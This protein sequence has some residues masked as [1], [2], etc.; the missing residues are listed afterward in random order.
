[1][2]RLLLA[3]SAL[4]LLISSCS[5][6]SVNPN[7]TTKPVHLFC[8]AEKVSGDMLVG[9][10]GVEFAN[11]KARSKKR[12][13][14]G[15]YSLRLHKENAY[16]YGYIIKDVKKGTVITAE[17][18]KNR[19]AEGGA[20]V[21]S[22][23]GSNQNYTSSGHF[24]ELE[25]EWGKVTTM[26]IAEQ[27]F[28]SLNVYTY[29]LAQKPVYFDDFKIGIYRNVSKP[30]I[31]SGA[32]VLKIE[33]PKSAQDSLNNFQR[34]ALEQ[35]VISS[36][37]KEYVKAYVD[38]NGEKAPVEL[39]LKGD[40]TD[41]VETE[42]VSFRIKMGDGY[43][44]DGLRT[45]SIQHPQTRSYA[46]EWFAHQL[47]EEE[48]ILTTR[49]EMIPVIINGKN[50]GVYAMEEHF[51]KQLLE[52]RKRREGPIMKFDESGIWAVHKNLKETGDYVGAP[53]IESAEISV[54]KKGRTKRTPTLFAQFKEAQSNMEKYR[55]GAD[56][57]E[58]Y[59]DI[60]ST[61]KYLALIEL[62]NGKHGLTWH[63]Q[64]FYFNPITQRLEPIAYDCFME[65]NL[66]IKQHEL[67]ALKEPDDHEFL[68]TQGILKD[69][70]LLERYEFYLE[71][72]SDP[73]YLS[74]MFDKLSGKI[75]K[76]EKLLSYEYPN[77]TV[78]KEHFEFNRT[79]ITQDLPQVKGANLN[80]NYGGDFGVLPDNFM[81]EEVA[82]KANL[83]KYNADSSAQMSLRN[84]HSHPIEIIGYTV[85]GD[86]IGLI[87][88]DPILLKAYGSGES[89]VVRFP[90]KPRRIHYKAA[91]CGDQ[92]FKCNP[93][94]WPQ[95]KVKKSKWYDAERD[96]SV[97][98]ET[99]TIS[100]KLTLNKGLI[101][102]AYKELV[103]E[104][105]AEIVLGSGA[106][107]VSHAPVRAEGT[108]ENPII[109]RGTSE[110]T[111]G[112]VCLSKEDSKLT[113]VTFDNLG[114]MHEENWRLTGAVTFYDASVSIDHCTFK[115]NHCEDGLNTISCNVT[116]SN[117]IVENTYSDG[118]DADFCTGSV[119][120]STFTNTGN[121]CI[122]FSGSEFKIINCTIED[123]G[124]KGISGGESSTLTVVDCT[125]NGA[126]IAV[127]SKDASK[128]EVENITIEKSDVAFSVYA[129][130]AEY[131][132]AI[133]SVKSVKKNNAKELK[134]L[135]K[136]SVL[137]YKG[138]EYI[139]TKKFNIDEMYA[140]FEK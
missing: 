111:Q 65:V 31:S 93:E 91:N 17:V 79:S 76:V 106:Y 64:R 7:D 27:D 139:G 13:R 54:F 25:G 62:T 138:K 100:G 128:V 24:R 101:I 35:G 133:L 121:D 86:G 5:E 22:E 90:V 105:G 46:M 119:T 50:C 99:Y 130:K 95:A 51:D 103:I 18:W 42:K 71:K 48:G 67:I 29:N 127:A 81:Y 59:M 134:L 94:E 72:Y 61:A 11:A 78:S 131:G 53:V 39:R 109:I 36:D 21:V 56:N 40:W 96:E 28:D 55:S 124:D 135:E 80:P 83:E 98:D 23:F 113:H 116:M 112:F 57:V 84:F 136:G 2:K 115:N 19:D 77:I 12:S 104:P 34:I 74:E 123:S 6:E 87:A 52:A 120:N 125:I 41:H 88:M 102:P 9:K 89:K 137:N 10:D 107:F 14:T 63:N 118:Y 73:S 69:K 60:E 122:D 140:Q 49:Y 47:F 4:I 37:Q 132:P 26:F 44:F 43:A 3:L 92:I 108:E 30:K 114:T 16:G 68:L 58:E 70:K 38:V 33:I 126:Q 32:K 45:F 8:G 66:L 110:S 82:L 1:M 15:K 97:A 75:K 129:K 85:K 20:L 117:S